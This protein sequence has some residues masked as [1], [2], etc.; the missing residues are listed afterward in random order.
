MWEESRSRASLAMDAYADG[1]EQA[2]GIVYDALASRLYAFIGRFVASEAVSEDVLQQVF[3]NMHRARASFTKGASVEPWAYA[4]ARRAVIDWIRQS[5][6]RERVKADA[7][8]EIGASVHSS[9]PE[10]KAW[11]LQFERICRDQLALVPEK[12]RD[13]FVLVRVEGLTVEEAAKVLGTTGMAVK[14]RAH[15]AALLLQQQ[16]GQFEV[17]SGRP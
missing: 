3:L 5:R 14:L 15:R 13:A 7:E 9:T 1:D 2:F 12:L 11:T 10:G 16:L 8:R 6:G 17:R 4:I